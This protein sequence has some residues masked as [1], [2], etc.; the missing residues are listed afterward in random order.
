MGQARPAN[1]KLEIP[2][3]PSDP[4]EINEN[5]AVFQH[6]HLLGFI[7]SLWEPPGAY[8]EPFGVSGSS[9]RAHWSLPD[10]ILKLIFKLRELPEAHFR[11]LEASRSRSG[12][13]IHA[14]GSKYMLQASK[15]RVFHAPGIKSTL[16]ASCSR[17]Q[18]H[19]PGIKSMHHIHAPGIKSTLRASIH[20]PGIK[21][22]LWASNPCSGHQ[23]HAPGI[24]SMLQA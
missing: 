5:P 8:F 24:K 16:Q 15:W 12:H 13:Q 14:K 2:I 3:A 9:F 4:P 20:S 1:S 18:I 21:S 6:I 19:A 22:M 17:H 7:G 11:S 10:T 23:I